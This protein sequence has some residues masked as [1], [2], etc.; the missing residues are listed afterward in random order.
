MWLPD[1]SQ[2]PGPT[3]K[4]IAEAIASAIASGHLK[5]GSRLPTHRALADGLGVTV[6]TVTRGYAEAE[7]RNLVEARVG[8]G[9]YVRRVQAPKHGFLIAD[10]NAHTGDCID[11]SFSTALSINQEQVL[12]DTL[13]D[14]QRDQSLMHRLLQYHPECGMA[15]HRYAGK[16]WLEITGMNVADENHIIVSSGAQHG[17]FLTLL[18]LCQRGD[19]VLCDGLTYPGFI[20]ATRQLGLRVVGLDMDAEGSTPEALQLACKRYRPRLI[21]LMPRLNNPTS[22]RMTR[23]R[24][25]SLT[26]ICRRHNVFVL[27]DDTQGCLTGAEHPT[28]A[29]LAPDITVL[30]TSCSKAMTGGLRIGF[31]YAPNPAFELIA[32]ALRVCCWMVSPLMAEVTCRWI[33]AGQAEKM[34]ASQ[35]AE[36]QIRHQLVAEAFQGYHYEANTKAFNVWLHLPEHWRA[37]AFAERAAVENVLIKPAEVFAAGQYPAPQAIRLCLGGNTTRPQ[38]QE[39]LIRLGFIK[40][41]FDRQAPAG[42][43]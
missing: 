40:K 1:L 23:T 28:F 5:S 13:A 14:I 30:V 43:I 36:L 26:A 11:L 32:N 21:Y 8:S 7:R 22:R 35:L 3:Y 42:L 37:A 29:N 31:I 33:M 20:A 19:T 39:G 2:Y 16:R 34:L 15:H 25:Q 38:L 27:E 6:G 41:D 24:I 12:T 4:A 10:E 18:S 9:T 17:F